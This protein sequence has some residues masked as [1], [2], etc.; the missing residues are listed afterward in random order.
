MLWKEMGV[1]EL[2]VGMPLLGYGLRMLGD[3]CKV[4]SVEE[5][6]EPVSNAD[7]QADGTKRSDI[8]PC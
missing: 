2:T 8:V 6:G 3:E 1:Q 7:P 4:S 5:E